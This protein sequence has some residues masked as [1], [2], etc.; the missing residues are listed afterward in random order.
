MKR[1]LF[2]F[3]RMPARPLRRL[4]TLLALLSL[5]SGQAVAGS[6]ADL[7][8]GRYV[9]FAAGCVS[10]HGSG[11][12]LSGGQPLV[13]PFGT[14]YPPNITPDREHGIGTWNAGDFVRALR[15]G[16]G[17]GGE[18]YYPAFPYTSYTRMSGEDM[19]A[20]Y[21]Y[22]MTQ[23]AASREN[24]PH[25]LP[26]FLSFR[27][28]L[29][30]WKAEYFTPGIM[31][32]DP[33]RTPQWNRGAYLA[34]ALGHCGECHTPRG[35]LGAPLTGDYLAGT[36][37]GPGG[38]TVPNITPDAATGIGGWTAGDLYTFLS[39]GRRPKGRYAAPPMMEV[40]GTSVMPLTESDRRALATYLR[41][42]PPVFHDVYTRYDP[43]APTWWRQ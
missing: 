10:C 20:L 30:D 2:P 22:L 43:F 27:P 6:D 4:Q 38:V 39:T 18:P 33:A 40:L 8:R 16:V 26:W 23:P 35:L 42:V 19:R 31:R 37:S 9:F 36:R 24:R 11:P 15:E 34:K 32:E 13:T 28:L 14:F 5:L 41:S 12:T 1:M 25:E 7:Q 29:R 21:A 3:R 17:P